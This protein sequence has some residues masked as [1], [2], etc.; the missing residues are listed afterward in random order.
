[1]CIVLGMHAEYL[2]YIPS[3]YETKHILFSNILFFLFF[4]S[5]SLFVF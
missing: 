5:V 1:M 3:N 4:K 2:Y